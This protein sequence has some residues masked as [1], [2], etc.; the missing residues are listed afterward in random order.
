MWVSRA[1]C[2]ES[3]R[4]IASRARDVG[5]RRVTTTFIILRPVCL[6]LA[7]RHSHSSHPL[8]RADTQQCFR[9]TLPSAQSHTDILNRRGKCFATN[10]ERAVYWGAPPGRPAIETRLMQYLFPSPSGTTGRLYVRDS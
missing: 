1:L 3:D 5:V 4:A 6:A 2:L 9:T 10:D 7:P 8:L